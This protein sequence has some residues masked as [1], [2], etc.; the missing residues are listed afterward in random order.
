VFVDVNGAKFYFDV[1]GSRLVPDGATMRVKPTLVL[2][3]GG[4][5]FDHTIYKPDLSVLAEIVQIIYFDH[6]GN[7]RSTGMD[8]PERAFGP[9]ARV[10][11]DEHIA[12]AA[13]AGPRGQTSVFDARSRNSAASADKQSQAS[14]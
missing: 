5:G 11:P 8:D 6:R 14:T 1:E 12:Q 3:H 7:G 9:P 10:H 13:L 2:L 4:P